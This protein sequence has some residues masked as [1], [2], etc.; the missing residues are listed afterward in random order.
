MPGSTFAV[1]IRGVPWSST[2]T[3]VKNFFDN[4]D[5]SES[6]IRFV[7]ESNGRAT[8]ECFVELSTAEVR[9]E[10]RLFFLCLCGTR[11]ASVIHPPFLGN[12][13]GHA[14]EPE[15]HGLPLPGNFSHLG[16]RDGL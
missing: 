1:K 14:E 2:E 5:I 15:V 11:S 13:A 4:L 3:D 9:R 10:K 12:A 16:G 6:A 7:Y 8:G